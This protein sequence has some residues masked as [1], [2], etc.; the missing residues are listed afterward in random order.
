MK[1]L[2]TIIHPKVMN[3]SA[4]PELNSDI[5]DFLELCSTRPNADKMLIVTA[6][7]LLLQRVVCNHFPMDIYNL[8][9][10]HYLS[11]KLYPTI[12]RHYTVDNNDKPVGAKVAVRFGKG[13]RLYAERRNGKRSEPVVL[14]DMLGDGQGGEGNVYHLTGEFA[15]EVAK[16]YKNGQFPTNKFIA[17]REMVQNRR[18]E[19]IIWT[20][21][22]VGILYADKDFTQPVGIME[23][24]T[25]TH[26]SLYDDELFFGDTDNWTRS[27]LS[28][29]VSDLL[30]LCKC[31]TRQICYLNMLGVTV[32]D[33][34][35]K[36]FDYPFSQ[37]DNRYRRSRLDYIQMWDSDSF[38][39]NNYFSG[40]MA[41]VNRKNYDINKKTDILDLCNDELYS[42]LFQILT[43]GD[44]PYNP[45]TGRFNY[46]NDSYYQY[47]RKNLVPP[48]L[49]KAFESFFT[50]RSKA[51]PQMMLYLLHEELNRRLRTGETDVTYRELVS[52]IDAGF[53]DKAAESV[54]PVYSPALNFFPQGNRVT[55]EVNG[56]DNSHPAETG[57]TSGQTGTTGTVTGKSEIA[58]SDKN[59]DLPDKPKR[60]LGCLTTSVV[61]IAVMVLIILLLFLKIRQHQQASPDRVLSGCF[62]LNEL[63]RGQQRHHS[64]IPIELLNDSVNTF[65]R[66]INS[67]GRTKSSAEVAYV[68]FSTN[69]EVDS[70]FMPARN[71]DNI[72]LKTVREGGTN[73][74]QAVLRAYEKLEQ[75]VAMYEQMGLRYNVPFFVLVTDGNPDDNKPSAPT[76]I[77]TTAQAASLF[78]LSSASAAVW[79]KI[80]CCAIRRALPTAFFTSEVIPSRCRPVLR[81][82]SA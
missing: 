26:S 62:A 67:D 77:R 48:S 37:R 42:F 45:V 47:A 71:L 51:S 36:N 57:G 13:T 5:W 56:G 69:I 81:T 72:H 46:E 12:E 44:N 61:A 41:D 58:D 35:I 38:G 17:T 2:N 78:L 60:K 73:M 68:T 8:N 59:S 7:R 31:V 39:Y 33:Y 82:C 40:Y 1:Q 27:L 20:V 74:A 29:R 11:H 49:W 65:I 22:P 54:P 14:G 19:E 16:I 64:D 32:A 75:R 34:N 21:F 23:R 15:G 6:N 55:P 80:P 3:L 53:F 66:E 4:Y 79:T 43:L 52:R 10:N 30:Y 25:V 76:A 50:G 24:Y 63:G 70:Q 28:V 18:F 9:T